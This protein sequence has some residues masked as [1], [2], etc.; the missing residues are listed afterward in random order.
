MLKSAIKEGMNFMTPQ[1]IKLGEFLEKNQQLIVIG[2]FFTIFVVVISPI[3]VLIGAII[4]WHLA[5]KLDEYR[6]YIKQR[7]S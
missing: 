7:G 5:N 3:L 4:M 1:D 6:R 2:W